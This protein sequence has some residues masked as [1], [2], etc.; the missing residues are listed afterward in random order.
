MAMTAGIAPIQAMLDPLAACRQARMHTITAAIE[1][2]IHAIPTPLQ[3]MGAARMAIAGLPVGPAIQTCLDAIAAVVQL[4][5]DAR[6]ALV[7]PVL[8]AFTATFGHAGR[9]GADREDGQ[10]PGQ[11]GG[12]EAFHGISRTGGVQGETSQP[13]PG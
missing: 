1:P 8:D 4:A 12:M 9:G 6:P 13:M 7:E 2:C 5:F 11:G 3:R 10:G